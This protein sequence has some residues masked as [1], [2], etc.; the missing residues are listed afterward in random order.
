MTPSN[1]LTELA[2]ILAEWVAPAPDFT[3]YLFG[4]RVRG[5]HRPDSDVDVVIAPGRN[6]MACDVTWW[7][8]INED[9]FRSINAQLPGP[10][11]ILENNDPIAD[12]VRNAPV[13]YRDRQVLCVW[14]EPK[15]LSTRT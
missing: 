3:I 12:L 8:S 14:R 9:L 15:P 10:L 11:R 6:P 2:R 13:V 5:D 7:S 4:S 1:D